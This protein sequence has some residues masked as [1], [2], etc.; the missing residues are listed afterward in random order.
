MLD[1]F[2]FFT[3]RDLWAMYSD[4][5]VCQALIIL[6]PMD[7]VPSPIDFSCPDSLSHKDSLALGSPGKPHLT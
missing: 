4:L 6:A 2:F 7:S 3:R 1:F 5:N